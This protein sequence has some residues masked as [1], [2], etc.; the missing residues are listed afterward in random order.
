MR[1]LMLALLL[2]G[3]L[4]GQRYRVAR[5]TWDALIRL[6]PEER[7]R[8]AV[9]AR[10]EPSG[11]AIWVRGS[12]L[13]PGPADSGPEV[14][15]AARRYS[16][17]VTAGSILTW[18]GSAVSVAGSVLYFTAGGGWRVAGA[19]MA[20]AAEPVMMTGTVLW[21]VGGLKHADEIPSGRPELRYLP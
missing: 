5:G 7:A 18:V 21:V 2:S 10:R 14:R 15:V 16:G 20:G 6:A 13:L 4:V 9:A 8:V 11:P 19:A 17:M 3:C 12:S 1:W